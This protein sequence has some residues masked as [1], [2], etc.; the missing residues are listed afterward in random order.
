MFRQV[1]MDGSTK[2]VKW[3]QE[4]ATKEYMAAVSNAE[5]HSSPGQDFDGQ[6]QYSFETEEGAQADRRRLGKRGA[7]LCKETRSC[8]IFLRNIR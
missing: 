8:A 3:V 6:N 2:K 1:G 4:D 5:E 7:K